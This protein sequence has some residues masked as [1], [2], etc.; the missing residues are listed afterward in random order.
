MSYKISLLKN[1]FATLFLIRFSY[2]FQT[3]MLNSS[4]IGRC[5]ICVLILGFSHPKTV[6]KTKNPV[7]DDKN[8]KI[9]SRH[10]QEPTT[11][12]SNQDTWFTTKPN[13]L[14]LTLLEISK[15]WH[16][17]NHFLVSSYFF[18]L[19]IGCRTRVFSFAVAFK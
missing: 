1:E 17:L 3:I 15:F 8:C 18:G 7:A 4:H 12:N 5:T 11:L 19:H 9:F 10:V 16:Y 14:S 2:N 6:K 13:P